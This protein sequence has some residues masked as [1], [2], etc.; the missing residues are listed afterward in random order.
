[1]D[2]RSRAAPTQTP[3]GTFAG[4]R[5]FLRPYRWHIALTAVFLVLSAAGAL[6]IPAAV[7]QVI[8]RGFMAEDLADI[9]RWFW[10]LFLAAAVM[11]VAGGLRFY[12][13]SW[14]GQHI[15]A[16]LRKGVYAR[17]LTMTPEF[18][19][20]TQTGELLSR[21]NTDTTLVESLVTSVVS[22]G[23]RNALMLVASAI[24]LMLTAPTLAGVI[25]L[26]IAGIMVPA[27]L[28]GRWV[29]SLSRNAQDRIADISA[30]G[31]ESITAIQTVQAFA[32]ES[33]EQLRFNDRVQQAVVAAVA[34]IRAS[35]LLIVTV[36][37]LTFAV[38]SFVLWLGARA[39]LLGDMSPGQLG[40]FVLYA[41][42]AAASTAA[43]S[44]IWGQLQRAAGATERLLEL[45]AMTPVLSAPAQPETLPAGALR[46][47]I[48]GVH[49]AYPSRPD[50]PALR[51][52]SCVIE[53][54]QTVAIVGASGAGKSTLLQ[55]LLRFHDPCQGQIRL[56]GIDLRHLDL[57]AFRRAIG[58]V[59]QQVVI[60]TGTAAENI[61]YGAP[62]AS[63]TE[64]EAAAKAAHADAFI[65]ALPDGYDT[66]LGERGV[67]LS[68]GQ[69]QR[70]AIARALLKNPQ[71]LLLDEA[72]ASLDAESERLVQEALEAMAEDRT[73][74]VIAHRLATV[75]R[76]DR[77]LV[78]DHGQLIAEGSHEQLMD[79]SEHYARLARLQ[80]L[81]Q[82][83]A[84]DSPLKAAHT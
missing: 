23:I 73:V 28:I 68:G 38:I 7:G 60:F 3:L 32:Q 24:A 13:V 21:L 63:Q 20:R 74:V 22:F 69:R 9:N 54:G 42:I 39:V 37:L 31:D 84:E 57:Q 49:F 35:T 34:R 26:L 19:D 30:A 16:D 44:E 56:G 40:Q 51:G 2:S 66:N 6:A 41:A 61:T 83:P 15:V 17:L 75:R 48:E 5:P 33:R 72:T 58:L 1:M 78:L 50:Q 53:P 29:R 71:L 77:I 65:R 45:L 8:D 62:E 18:F 43:L 36:I 25:A 76:A 59:P 55:L 70:I 46:I 14:L 12:M 10:F 67:A 81:D 79:S 80:F 64:I 52:L 82:A 27:V 4:L 11:A 47:D